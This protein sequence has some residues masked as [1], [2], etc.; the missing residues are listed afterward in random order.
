VNDELERVVTEELDAVSFDLVELRQGG[1]RS[2]GVKLRVVEKRT[3][4]PVP[5]VP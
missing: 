3:W 4:Y 2:D 1:T 5:V